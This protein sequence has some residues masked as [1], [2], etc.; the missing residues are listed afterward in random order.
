MSSRLTNPGARMGAEGVFG[1]DAQ[2][3]KDERELTAKV[4]QILNRWPAVGFALGVVR[5]GRLVYFHGH[6]LADIA[7]H[8]PVTEDTVFRI[9]SITK[10]ITA[11]AV[12]QLWEQ[13]RIDLDAAA[14]DYLR[15]YKLVPAKASFRP[16]TVRQLL[17]HTAGIPEQAHPLGLLRPDW[18]ETVKLG[19]PLPSLAE[20]YR[21]GLRV[22]VEP[23]STFMY[24]DHS[25]A[26]LGQIVEDV[27]GQ[28]LARYFRE[29]IFEPLGM[30]DT[31]LLRSERVQSHLATGYTLGAAGPK[32]ASDREMIPAAAGAV[33]S[34]TRDMARYVAA[35]L[36]G[37]GSEHGSV[38][39]P[40]TMAMMFEPHYQPDPRI[41]GMGLAFFRGN[42]DGH[43][44][45]EHQGILPGFNSQ[46][47]L[48]PDEGVGVLA[49][50]NGARQAVRWMPAE[51]GRLL[52]DLLGVPAE[53][54]R[55]DVPQQPEI[56]GDLCGWYQPSIPLTDVRARMFFGA[57]AEVF[58]QRGE[59]RLRLLIPI[60]ALYK[61]FPLHPA[62]DTDPDVFQ[63]DFS[64]FGMPI[65]HV[66]FR[67]D[68]G[69]TSALL[70][71]FQPGILHKQ[72]AKTNPRVWAT[73]ALGALGVLGVAAT[74]VTV[75]R[76][77]IGGRTERQR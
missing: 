38:L 26:T 33:Y 24:G 73:G 55:A 8:T 42:L 13:G 15:S 75:G 32:A 19:Q 23:G 43:V 77:R 34:T 66:V 11:I 39:T 37:G 4:S 40:T 56:W 76:R 57:G 62:D 71:D 14:N 17:T 69:Q 70:L 67:R 50:T 53:A 72:P 46:I 9:G 41:P 64:E 31:D 65:G 30:E 28:P 10:T 45:V 18:G 48:A 27:S 1:S 60:P 63:L 68:S 16:A 44:T 58:V 7:S 59:L 52:G 49:F 21:G 2:G 5:E 22:A 20:Y 51:L 47:W 36:G 6:G 12:M 74:A 35:L 3:V 25:I 29:H 54:I 61:G